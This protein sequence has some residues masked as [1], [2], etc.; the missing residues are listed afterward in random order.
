MFLLKINVQFRTILFA[1]ILPRFS[2]SFIMR[3]GILIFTLYVVD[4]FHFTNTHNA[5]WYLVLCNFSDFPFFQ[6][7]LPPH[8][9]TLLPDTRTE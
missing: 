8:T 1:M 5:S 2:K 3:F 6:N 7:S 4:K 9:Y